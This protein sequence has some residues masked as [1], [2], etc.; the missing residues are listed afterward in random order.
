[1]VIL[2]AL[3]VLAIAVAAIYV[4]WAA[5]A[6]LSEAAFQGVL[7]AALTRRAK[8]ISN[9]SWEGSVIRATAIPFAA[10]LIF[11]VALGWYAQKHCPTAMRLRE[12]IHCIV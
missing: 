11:A 10:V 7:A 1:V 5:P 8:K 9:G 6:I 12:A 2:V 4:I 3:L